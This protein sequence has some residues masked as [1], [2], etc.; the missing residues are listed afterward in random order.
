MFGTQL[1]EELDNQ[2]RH[3]QGIVADF[4]AFGQSQMYSVLDGDLKARISASV[5]SYVTT[6]KNRLQAMR[7][8]VEA[9]NKLSQDAG[10]STVPVDPL[11]LDLQPAVPET[12]VSH[13]PATRAYSQTPTQPTTRL[14]TVGEPEDDFEDVLGP[15]VVIA[16]E[17]DPVVPSGHTGR[18]APRRSPVPAVPV[19][20]ES[21]GVKRQ[22][23]DPSKRDIG[24]ATIRNVSENEMETG[25]MPDGPVVGNQIDDDDVVSGR[26]LGDGDYASAIKK[27]R[28][29]QAQAVAEKEAAAAKSAAEKQTVM[30][31][32]EIVDTRDV[33][34]GRATTMRRVGK[35]IVAEQIEIYLDRMEQDWSEAISANDS[36]SIIKNIRRMR[37]VWKFCSS[38]ETIR[39][40]VSNAGA[41]GFD[42]DDDLMLLLDN[43]DLIQADLVKV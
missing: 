26:A 20:K 42:K 34:I 4:R 3:L 35:K 13:I 18:P 11:D 41:F 9:L 39:M 10:I 12:V 24:G 2:E 17:P 30:D 37:E 1:V 22:M 19:D 23:K 33:T 32:A 5:R 15:T 28:A 29:K 7:Q 16:E 8:H 31:E 40:A 27:V 38:G 36:E 25:E 14:A 21:E 6:R 43:V